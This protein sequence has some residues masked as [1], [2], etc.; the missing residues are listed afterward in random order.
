MEYIST[1]NKR[2]HYTFKDM[3]LK[4]LATD[5]GL[6]VPNK[7]PHYSSKD[8]DSLKE[9]PYEQL[10]TKIIFNYCSDQFSESEINELVKK[11]Y[12]K[13]TSKDVVN[14]KKLR[15]V[16]LLELFQT[17]YFWYNGLS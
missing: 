15:N 1:R 7:I 13:F 2:N 16:N 10:A 12:K 5:G 8:L 14:I 11:S 3:F 17:K 6:Y 9:L 4:G